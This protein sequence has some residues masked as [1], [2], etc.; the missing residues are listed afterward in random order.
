M[1]YLSVVENDVETRKIALGN[2]PLTVGREKDNT[3]S[4][5]GN[6][7]SRYH[8][9]LLPPSPA[10]GWR[11]VDLGS[12]NGTRVNGKRIRE[13]A[14]YHGDRID[15]G[16]CRLLLHDPSARRPAEAPAPVE[17]AS[18]ASKPSAPQG[19]RLVAR[20]NP[21]DGRVIP[22]AGETTIGRGKG[23]DLAI[24]SGD[25]SGN[26]ATLKPAKETF[27]ILDLGSTN[28]T[29]VNGHLVKTQDLQHGDEIE[30]GPV[31]FLFLAQE[32]PDEA[33]LSA[34]R[35]RRMARERRFV[36][37]PEKGG[38]EI[39][40]EAVPFSVG[41][42]P[43]N[44]L[45][46]DHESVSG[47]HARFLYE[48]NHLVLEDLG[49][50]NGTF[51]GG[52]PVENTRVGHGDDL[53]FGALYFLLRDVDYPFP[54]KRA[55]KGTFT[56]A[57][58][59]ALGAAV[60]AAAILLPYLFATE[61]DSRADEGDPNL[62]K[63]NPSF[64]APP[65][66][67]GTLEGWS[68]V[69]KTFALDDRQAAHGACSLKVQL[70]GDALPWA[71][72]EARFEKA[73]QIKKRVD[74]RVSCRIRSAFTTGVA[75]IRID[76]Q[77]R[78]LPFDCTRSDL[79]TGDTGWLDLAT[80]VTPPPGAVSAR[81]AL[82][83]LG[84]GGT[85]WFDDVRFAPAETSKTPSI[86]AL[87]NS[88]AKA[89]ISRRG[90]ITL[91]ADGVPV[92]KEAGLE[93]WDRS[94]RPRGTQALS[95]PAPD[96]P[97]LA[98]NRFIL[99]SE[100][101]KIAEGLPIPFEVRFGRG[102]SGLEAVYHLH[103]DA[104]HLVAGD[105]IALALPLGEAVRGVV[106]VKGD[107]S[108]ETFGRTSFGSVMDVTAVRLNTAQEERILAFAPPLTVNGLAEDGAL[109]L[110]ASAGV[111]RED[112]GKVLEISVEMS[113]PPDE[114]AA[115]AAALVDRAE[116][117]LRARRLGQAGAVYARVAREFPGATEAIR[118]A[119]LRLRSLK[120]DLAR[121]LT[122]LEAGLR[123]L[124]AS[125]EASAFAALLSRIGDTENLFEG[126]EGARRCR[127]YRK[128]AFE[129]YARVG[130]PAFEEA[131]TLL[132]G[133]RA[134]YETGDWVE[135]EK[136]CARILGELQVD[137]L[138]LEA[139]S[140]LSEIRRRREDREEVD[141]WVEDRLR[142]ARELETRGEEAVA[143]EVYGE[144]LKRYPRGEWAAFA[145]EQIRR[146]ER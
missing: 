2:T 57:H 65:A 40:I 124:E 35:R 36:L 110:F 143:R 15:V 69:G 112:L 45:V 42:D 101:V 27:R 47:R 46:L 144:I 80:V 48:G 126:M 116:K 23:N 98:S 95:L 121:R 82:V 115:R 77:G 131:R 105:R 64:E 88:G 22:L 137:A 32:R 91:E 127:A 75:G 120:E 55:G 136:A 108:E 11:I 78:D 71:R 34:F 135:A 125:P 83:A 74:H 141:A 62:L 79:V 119:D 118:E 113:R 37:V 19:F 93:F 111:I 132:S 18:P 7:I 13:T 33:S 81:L 21:L 76:W 3:I 29:R 51:A 89:W 17:T 1:A 94:R 87:A 58:W 100:A 63:T 56:L 114:E 134:A 24:D 61:E 53:E 90:R 129:A 4:L 30:I 99:R 28:G 6:R 107:G 14:L 142:A 102:E 86:H 10:G 54:D 5:N 146:L 67:D 70:S 26:H 128:R 39:G 73:F 103:A 8:C 38:E 140:I 20:G 85:V 109:R 130:G 25:V 59:I 117:L 31:R 49:S 44:D 50:T 60:L 66:P 122:S 84:N 43:D 68:L 133:A 104:G 52:R 106:L 92:V 16:T 9:R 138:A 96:Y 72:A 41:R 97:R 123:E 145:K 12:A 139:R